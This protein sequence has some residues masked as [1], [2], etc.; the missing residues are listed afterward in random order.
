MTNRQKDYVGCRKGGCEGSVEKGRWTKEKGKE[1][2]C[3]GVMKEGNDERRRKGGR[4]K[5]GKKKKKDVWEERRRGKIGQ[6]KGREQRTCNKKREF[7]C[8][9]DVS[10]QGYKESRDDMMDEWYVRYMICIHT[11]PLIAYSLSLSPPC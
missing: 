4:R 7:S 10:G 6:E 1:R 9:M 2:G 5:R 11:P 3:V 8:G